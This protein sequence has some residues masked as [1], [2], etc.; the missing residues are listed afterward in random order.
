MSDKTRWVIDP[1]HSEIAFKI[2]HLMIANVRGV[3]RKFEAEVFTTGLDFSTAE[4]NFRIESASID[5]NNDNRDAHLRGPD[6]FDSDKHKYIV[7]ISE[8]IEASENNRTF[9]LWGE[10]TIRGIKKQIR[11]DVESGGMIK[12]PWGKEKAGFTISGKLNRKDWELTWNQALEA[13]GAMLSDDV[14]IQCEVELA[15]VT[16]ESENVKKNEKEKQRQ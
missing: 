7:F 9:A 11:L 15:M 10:L 6:F 4:V 2:R 3:F 1:M 13:G 16:D 12:D 8:R 5:T 14:H